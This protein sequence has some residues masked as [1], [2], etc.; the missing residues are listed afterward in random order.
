MGEGAPFG[1]RSPK[2][3]RPK[4]SLLLSG[5]F[6]APSGGQRPHLRPRRLRRPHPP[7]SAFGGGT[8]TSPYM[9]LALAEADRA[10][11]RTAPNPPF[12]AVLVRDGT[13]VGRGHT[14]PA[15]DA[16]AEVMALRQAGAAAQG[17]TLYVTLEPCCHVGRTPPCTDALIRAGVTSVVAAV[18]DRNPRVASRGV[19]Q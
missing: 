12:G 9:A 6:C 1:V 18:V 11:G 5:F 15:G 13:V 10:R 3:E 14:Q 17:A 2:A 4:R 16:H 19:A 8:V 7:P